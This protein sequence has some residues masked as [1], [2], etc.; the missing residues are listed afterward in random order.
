MIGRIYAIKSHQTDDVYI[1]STVNTLGQRLIGHKSDYKK[2]LKGM[3]AYVSSFEIIQHDDAFIELLEEV[4]VEDRKELYKIEGKYIKDMDCVNKR[5]AGRSVKDWYQENKE[6]MKEYNKEYRNDNKEYYKEYHKEYRNENKEKM[7]EKSKEYRNAN[8]EKISEKSKVKMT[9]ECGSVVRKYE[10][11]RHIR[12]KKHKE[13]HNAN[14]EKNLEKMKD[15][16]QQNKVQ[17]L[18]RM[19]EIFTCECGST[20]AFSSLSRHKRTNKHKKYIDS[21]NEISKI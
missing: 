1:G 11:K 10:I 19:K 7:K 17:I 5:I 3:Y 14:K 16:Y 21:I 9:C 15:Y 2:Y 6:K 13:Y 18:E 8:K 4:N 20:I 12:S